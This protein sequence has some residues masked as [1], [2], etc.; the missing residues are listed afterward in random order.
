MLAGLW[1][2]RNTPQLLVGLQA[3]KT[4]L[5]INMAVP[6]KIGFT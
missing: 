6:D 4:T 2:K 1:I 3:G 5:E